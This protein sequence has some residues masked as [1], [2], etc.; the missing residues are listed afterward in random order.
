MGTLPLSK[1]SGALGLV[2][3]TC[4]R[5]IGVDAWG[6]HETRWARGSGWA[7]WAFLTYARAMGIRAGVSHRRGLAD[8]GPGAGDTSAVDG[9]SADRWWSVVSGRRGRRGMESAQ[10][11]ESK[12]DDGPWRTIYRT[13]DGWAV[14]LQPKPYVPWTGSG[15]PGGGRDD[16]PGL[17]NSDVAA[18]GGLRPLVRDP[19]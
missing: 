9:T 8:S 17:A 11:S 3:G 4:D 7:V 16:G 14:Q 5:R 19:G 1:S 18:H 6:L 15:L 10:I 13:C 2:R 12:D